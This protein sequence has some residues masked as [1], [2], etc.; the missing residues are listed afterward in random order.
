[1]GSP[2]LEKVRSE[3]LS[4]S[5]AER[6]ELAHNLVASLDGP[7]DPD[8]ETA[9]D[10]EILRRLAEIDSGTANLIDREEFRRRMRD[11]MSRS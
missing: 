3:A 11:R 2:T 1:M 5:E 7:A 4:L 10:A 6:A 9:W 8:V